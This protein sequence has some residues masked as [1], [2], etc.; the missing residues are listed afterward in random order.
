MGER[1]VRNEEASGSIPLSSTILSGWRTGPKP[2]LDHCITLVPGLRGLGPASAFGR[3]K[4]RWTF[5]SSASPLKFC[6]PIRGLCL[7]MQLRLIPVWLGL[8]TLLPLAALGAEEG[9][10]KK[11]SEHKLTQADVAALVTA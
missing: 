4:V 7:A 1:L 11:K 9:G 2:H 8:L 5:C 6:L 3:Q 10:E